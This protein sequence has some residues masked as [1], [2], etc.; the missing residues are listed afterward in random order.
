MNSFFWV[1]VCF[2]AGVLGV[3]G[4]YLGLLRNQRRQNGTR[5]FDA[6]VA[7]V[8]GVVLAGVLPPLGIIAGSLAIVWRNDG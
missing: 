5:L 8:F 6:G 7:S 3:I 2:A 4:S 1:W